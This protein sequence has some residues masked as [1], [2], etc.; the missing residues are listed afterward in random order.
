MRSKSHRCSP[1]T[2]YLAGINATIVKWL[3]DN[4]DIEY[5]LDF[6]TDGA[7]IRIIRKQNTYEEDSINGKS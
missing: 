3:G 7:V 5:D 2:F 4:Y 1:L 6:D